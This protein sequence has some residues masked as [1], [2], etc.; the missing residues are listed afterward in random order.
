MKSRKMT[1]VHLVNQKSAV[2]GIF[3]STSALWS[4]FRQVPI[5]QQR[6]INYIFSNLCESSTSNSFE[7]VTYGMTFRY[8]ESGIKEIWLMSD[9]Y[10][11]RPNIA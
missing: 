10:V 9:D 6:I 3:S 2:N 11:V 4:D 1:L 8:P 7:F 5:E